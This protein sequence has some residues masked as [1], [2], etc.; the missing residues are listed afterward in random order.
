MI[1][2]K[3]VE[4]VAANVDYL[5]REYDLDADDALCRIWDVAAD[6]NLSYPLT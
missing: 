1:L 5:V 6:G 3:A 2:S 4:L